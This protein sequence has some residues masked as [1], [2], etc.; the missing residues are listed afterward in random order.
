MDDPE[1][2][3]NLSDAAVAAGTQ[4]EALV[5]VDCGAGRCGVNTTQDVVNIAKLIDAAPG[6]KFA[7]IQA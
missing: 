4:I 6:L 1:N 2:V 5:E 7:G 3:K